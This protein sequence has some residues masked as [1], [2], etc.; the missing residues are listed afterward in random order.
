MDLENIAIGLV[1][2]GDDDDLGRIAKTASCF[3]TD[4]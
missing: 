2:P 1:K 4:T 3:V